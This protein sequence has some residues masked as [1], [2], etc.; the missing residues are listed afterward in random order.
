MR[1]NDARM[2]T[3]NRLREREKNPILKKLRNFDQN[4]KEK[5]ALISGSKDHVKSSDFIQL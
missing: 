4:R 2:S 3:Y 1:C 5:R